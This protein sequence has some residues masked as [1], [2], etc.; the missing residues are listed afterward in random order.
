MSGPFQIG[1]LV[2]CVS[3]D[4]W[5]GV[6]TRLRSIRRGGIYRVSGAWSDS[7]GQIITLDGVVAD[8]I[9]GGFDFSRFRKIRPADDQFIQQMRA[10]K[11]VREGVSA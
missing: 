2:C 4:P 9:L 7:D 10:I 11:P 1:D 3:T 6:G 8:T 5:L